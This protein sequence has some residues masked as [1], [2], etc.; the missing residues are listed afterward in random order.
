LV[1]FAAIVEAGPDRDYDD[2]ID[3]ACGAWNK[4][5]AMPHQI[6]SIAIRDW[7]HVGGGG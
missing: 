2:I 1:E 3:V 5:I 7:A 6:K 4:L